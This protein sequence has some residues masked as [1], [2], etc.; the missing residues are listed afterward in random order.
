M[1]AYLPPKFAG[2]TPILHRLSR[3]QALKEDPVTCP[4][5]WRPT[6]AS[7]CLYKG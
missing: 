2:L 6:G 7:G 4:L 1:Q 5:C 3:G